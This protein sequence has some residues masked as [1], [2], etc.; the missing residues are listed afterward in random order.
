MSEWTVEILLQKPDWNTDKKS[1]YLKNE[2]SLFA[3][4]RWIIL[5]LKESDAKEWFINLV[6]GYAI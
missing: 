4:Q 3:I 2:R 5:P 1:V 6:I